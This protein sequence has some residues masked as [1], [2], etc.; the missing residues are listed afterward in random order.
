ME[1]VD[2][3]FE[4][5]SVRLGFGEGPAAG[6][7]LVLLHGLME[8][9]RSF[10]PLLGSWCA[11][12]HVF[13]LDLR[14]H[15]TSDRTPG[16]YALDDDADDVLAFLAEHVPPQPVLLGH[17]QGA[18][19][20]CAVAARAGGDLK[21]LVLVDPPLTC[22]SD[23]WTSIERVLALFRSIHALLVATGGGAAGRAA[24]LERF[25]G[26]DLMADQTSRTDPNRVASVLDRSA[27]F[28]RRWPELL[29][30]VVCPTLLLQ[31]DPARGAALGDADARSALAVLADGRLERIAGAGHMIQDDAPEA[32]DRAVR[33]FLARG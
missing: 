18:L 9:R 13:A 19:I 32:Y 20:A 2:R 6:R 27:F 25:P 23:D 22:L 10:A 21:A 5:G 30:R 29:A 33:A 11:H 28:G 1:L 14:G 12:H 8:D 31:A 24:L 3:T 7:P 17:S 16:A 26:A 15:G 4:R